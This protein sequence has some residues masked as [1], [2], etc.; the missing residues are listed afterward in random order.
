MDSL[1]VITPPAEPIV[2]LTAMKAALLVDHSADDALIAALVAAATTEAQNRAARALVT[3]TLNLAL[4]AW[5]ADGAIRLWWPPTQSVSFVK[6]Y[7]GDGMLQT[8]AATDYTAIL[9]VCP[10]L[11]VPA[12]NKAWPSTSLRSFSPIRVQY[13]AG[14]GTAA[15]VAAADPELV[16]YV[17]ALVQVDYENRESIG[18]QAYQQR[19]RI[20]NALKAKWGWAG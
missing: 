15:A 4:D 5:P 6:Y 18:P 20:L 2:T 7:D 13:V 1:T 19:E 3:Q 10:A 9:D 16:H 11:V 8:V 17:K 14:Y 12:P